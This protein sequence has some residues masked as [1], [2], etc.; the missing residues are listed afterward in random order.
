MKIRAEFFAKINK[1]ANSVR[2]VASTPDADRAGDVVLPD[3]DLEGYKKNPVIL[4]N[5]NYESLVGRAKSISLDGDRL[6]AEIEFDDSEENQAGR[7]VKSQVERGFLNAVSVSFQSH[8][9]VLRSSLP[10]DDKNYSPS[11]GWALGGNELLELSVV[12]VPCNPSAVVIRSIE[13]D[14]LRIKNSPT[15]ANNATAEKD[16]QFDLLKSQVLMLLSDPDVASIM[17]Q[18]V[19]EAVSSAMMDQEPAQESAEEED[20]FFVSNSLFQKRGF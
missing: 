2:V 4:L 9:K 6:L 5:H 20:K 12:S 10:K 8:K 15:D 1:D 3:W 16:E 7:R 18:I 14:S 17:Q 11:G 13:E 19:A